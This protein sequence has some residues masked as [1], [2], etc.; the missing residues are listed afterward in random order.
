M[1]MH[2]HTMESISQGMGNNR[3]ALSNHCPEKRYPESKFDPEDFMFTSSPPK[4]AKLHHLIQRL[5][6]GAHVQNN[7]EF[8]RKQS[9]ETLQSWFAICE[10]GEGMVNVTEQ[11]RIF[12]SKIISQ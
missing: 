11:C 5:V 12:A 10:S 4:N 2:E 8:I 6:S 3:F 7:L 9:Q 1:E